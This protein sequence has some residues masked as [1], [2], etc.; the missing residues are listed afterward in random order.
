[1]GPGFKGSESSGHI[2]IFFDLGAGVAG[3]GTGLLVTFLEQRPGNA[4]A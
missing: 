2:T 3:T 4:L 1:M